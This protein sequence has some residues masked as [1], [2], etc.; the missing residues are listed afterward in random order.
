MIKECSPNEYEEIKRVLLDG[1]I[2]G[3]RNKEEFYQGWLSQNIASIF[4][5][6]NTIECYHKKYLSRN[7]QLL[8]FNKEYFTLKFSCYLCPYYLNKECRRRVFRDDKRKDRKR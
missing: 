6:Y 5:V 8:T 4:S 1:F 2:N 7:K 3:L